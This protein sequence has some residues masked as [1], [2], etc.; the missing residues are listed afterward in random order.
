VADHSIVVVEVGPRDGLQYGPTFFPTE[1]KIELIN[2]LSR[3]GLT[4]IEVTSFI[5]PKVIPNLVDAAEVVSGIKKV[6]GIIYSALVPNMKGCQRA[7]QTPIDELALFV[8]ASETHNQKNVGMSTE[9]SLSGFSEIATLAKAAGK[10]VRGYI[11]TAFGCPYEGLIPVERVKA[12]VNAYADMGVREVSLG[13]TTGMANPSQ[14]TD[15]FRELMHG[16]GKVSLAAHFH[17]S[18]GLGLAN[19]IA[20][21]QAGCRV[22]DSSL[23]GLGGCPTAEGA[24][25]N[26]PTEDLVNMMEEMGINTGVDFAKLISTADL[27]KEVLKANLVS[28][29]YNVGRPRWTPENGNALSNRP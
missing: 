15:S 23:G 3:T 16:N 8:S 29:T 26:I 25:G 17:N 10:S 11:A 28:H 20:A 14:V 7:L 13:D 6:A 27:V 18:R 19:A 5:H 12:I 24:M 9:E 1:A 4:R 21:Y 2:R 22:F